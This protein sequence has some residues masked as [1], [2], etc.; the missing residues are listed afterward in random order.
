MKKVSILLALALCIGPSAMLAQFE[1]TI[2]MK[3]VS[4]RD[5]KQAEMLYTMYVKKDMLAADVKGQ[6][7]SMGGGRFIFRGDKKVFWIINDQEKNYLE[8]SFKEDQR[9]TGKG[10]M[11]KH[12]K[13]KINIHPTGK[14]QTILGYACEEWEMKEGDEVKSV[15][16]TKKLGNVYEGIAKSFD[17]LGKRG[18]KEDEDEWVQLAHMDIFPLKIVSAENGKVQETQ[19]VTKIESKALPA[20]MF[21][22][23]SGYK[24]HS[25]R[26]RKSV[27]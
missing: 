21:E 5:D 23:P 8:M 7:E 4:Q 22:P 19:E 15:W 25:F 6:D 24:K 13:E 1:G 16:G 18:S 12:K 3:M 10:E 14:T 27:V 26:D 20:S 9:D 17:Q 2:D 11:K